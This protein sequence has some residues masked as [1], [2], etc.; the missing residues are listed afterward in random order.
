MKYSFNGP[1]I[2][3]EA[4][5]AQDNVTLIALQESVLGLGQETARRDYSPENPVQDQEHKHR[6]RKIGERKCPECS[7]FFPSNQ[8]LGI[9]RRN[10]HGVIGAQTVARIARQ[11][12]SHKDSHQ[13]RPV[14][15]S[16]TP[17]APESARRVLDIS[18]PGG[19]TVHIS[20]PPF[21]GTA[22]EVTPDGN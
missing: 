19:R 14:D 7:V 13:N 21:N 4:E 20:R 15:I 18:M 6:G 16:N 10:A 17:E 5:S 1:R 8:I 9:H 11:Q 2:V 22:P 3:V 12:D